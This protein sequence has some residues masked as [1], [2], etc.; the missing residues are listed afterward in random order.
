MEKMFDDDSSTKSG[1][2]D[3]KILQEY[4]EVDM[5]T[6]LSF[7]DGLSN[8]EDE[9]ILRNPEE[10]HVM[11]AQASN[12]NSNDAV[13]FI[14]SSLDQKS[15]SSS[16]D[17]SQSS[18]SKLIENLFSFRTNRE[19]SQEPETKS[20]FRLDV[21]LRVPKAITYCINSGDNEGLVGIIEEAFLPNCIIKT[22][23]LSKE[24]VG[25]NHII[26]FFLAISRSIPDFFTLVED[27]F[28]NLRVISTL[29]KSFGTRINSDRSEYL[30]NHLKH[31]RDDSNNYLEARKKARELIKEGQPIRFC[32]KSYVHLILNK[33]MT[34][35]EKFVV[36]RKSL[37]IF[38]PNSN[39]STI[40]RS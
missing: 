5:D 3:S 37:R 24:L 14:Q 25:R 13:E 39:T 2:N 8:G 40:S 23:A 20:E 16:D 38:D 9:K 15:V 27:P 35:V 4:C 28:L 1:L 30:F 36:A 32:S 31:G 10:Y 19:K 11:S 7:N 12:T 26:E 29:S 22:P 34:H 33:E 17:N 21:L 18:S 6:I